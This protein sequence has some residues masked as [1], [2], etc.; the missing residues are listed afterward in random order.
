MHKVVAL[1]LKLSEIYS[2]FN[3]KQKLRA[4]AIIF[5]Q[6]NELINYIKIYIYYEYNIL[7]LYVIYMIQK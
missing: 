3:D 1:T 4:S 6:I 7:F 2:I 5:K